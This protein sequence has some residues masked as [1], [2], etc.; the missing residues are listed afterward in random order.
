M[1]V[2]CDALAHQYAAGERALC[3]GLASWS[4]CSHDKEGKSSDLVLGFHCFSLDVIM[5]FCYAKNVDATRVP[6]FKC[7][8]VL[9]SEV[10]LPILTIRK[11]SSILVKTMPYIPIWFGKNYGFPITRSLFSL[12]EVRNRCLKQEWQL[13]R[14]PSTPD[15]YKPD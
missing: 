11:Y 12:K 2:L 8:I 4:Y 9:A 5:D 13:T 3:F 7:D 6:D 10:V 1:V 14:P 15:I